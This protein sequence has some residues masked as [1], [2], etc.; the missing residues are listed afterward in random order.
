MTAGCG[1]IFRIT[2]SGYTTLYGFGAD[3]HPSNQTSS[4]GAAPLDPLIQ[5][6][7]GN[8]YGTTSAAGQFTHGTVFKFS[9]ASPDT[10]SI[11]STG[12]V[13]NGASFQ[14]GI[15]GGSWMT[16]NGT[17]LSSKTDSWNNSI[18]NGALPTMLDGVSVMVGGQPAYIEYVSS[19]QINTLAPSVAAGNVAV[20][21]TN[22]NGTSQAAMVQLQSE[23]PAFFQWGTYAV[24][25]RQDF[26]LAS[27][28]EL[29]PAPPPSPLSPAT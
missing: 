2:P 27:R 10:P 20:S 22:S 4:D 13:L 25:T 15:S 9:L 26:S 7:D 5:A 29:S 8:F 19:T 1:T 16:I 28:T 3:F 23:Q 12:G 11:A 14:P 24:A 17:N 6:S 21:V 18:I